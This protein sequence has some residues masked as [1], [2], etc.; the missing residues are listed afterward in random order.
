MKR[1]H[2]ESLAGP[3]INWSRKKAY[4]PFPAA[5]SRL[6]EG[7]VATSLQTLA[8]NTQQKSQLRALTLQFS[9]SFPPSLRF[10]F[11]HRIESPPT[12]NSSNGVRRCSF[13]D[14]ESPSR[15]FRSR[16]HRIPRQ[17][18]PSPSLLVPLL[19]PP[20]ISA[21]GDVDPPFSTLR[22]VIC[23]IFTL[24][25]FRMSTKLD[26]EVDVCALFSVSVDSGF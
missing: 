1:A 2:G 26:R 21:R 14:G 12:T 11:L 4:R 24:D 9:P 6:V 13:G 7:Q 19:L 5:A 15:H 18:I 20:Q 3:S 16:R 25:T 8:I 17:V 23:W 10:F 22:A